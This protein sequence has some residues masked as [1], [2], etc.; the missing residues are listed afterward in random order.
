MSWRYERC[1]AA[2]RLPIGVAQQAAVGQTVRAGD[3]VASGT[4]YGSAVRVGGARALGIGPGDLDRVMRVARDAEVQ[5]GTII[6]RTGRRFARAVA[7]PIDG[8]IAHVRADGDFEVAPVVG[9]WTVR[10]TLDG[11]VTRADASEVTIEGDAWALS[12]VAAYGPD[13]F[14][15]LTLGVDAPSDDLAPGRIDVRQR[16][17]IIVGGSRSGAESIARAHACGITAVVSG[18]VPAGGLRSIY[19]EGVGAHGAPSREDAPTVLCL[20]GFGAARL[21]A[22]LWEPFVALNGRRAAIHVRSARLFVFAP[23]DAVTVETE[24]ALALAADWGSI[25]AV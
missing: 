18:A 14:G 13:A 15:E 4:S 21:P 2:H 6:A 12:G 3:V 17:R 19:G 25:A 7:A 20:L 1:V 10:A 9:T 5:R 11:V 16:G 22:Q 23:A 24:P 8:R